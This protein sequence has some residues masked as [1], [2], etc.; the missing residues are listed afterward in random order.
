MS[1]RL[2]EADLIARYFAPLAGPAGLGLRDDAAL[3]RPPPGEDLVLTTDALVAGVHFFAD[4]PPGAIARKA[5][6]VNLSDLAAKGARPLGFLLT[7]ALPCD[8]REDWLAVVRRGSWRGRLGLR[9]PAY[10]RRH[11]VDAWAHDAERDRD[12][13][14]RARADGQ[15]HRRQGRRPPL[16]HGHDRR[17]RDWS[18]GPARAGPRHS[19]GRQGVP[20]RAV[21]DARAAPGADRRDGRARERRHGRLGRLCR[22][23][24]PRCSTSPGSAPRVPI[25][26][27]PL[28]PAARAAIAADPDLFEVA[29]TGGDDYELLAS[30]SPA[31][32]SAFEAAAAA[33]GVP[34]T[35]VGEAVEGRRA[36]AL[37][38]PRW[39]CGRLR[40]RLLQPFLNGD[41]MTE[42]G[43]T[44]MDMRLLAAQ[45]VAREA[46]ALARR[47]FLDHSFTVGFKGPQDYLTEVDGETEA[48]I[49]ERLHRRLS[50]RRLHR[51]REQGARQQARA[52]R[53]GS[54]IRSTAPRTS[55][56]ACRI[57]A[58]RSPAS[59]PARSR[60]ASF[61][62]RCATNCSRPGEAAAR[63]STARRCAPRVRRSLA[64]LRNRGRLEHARGR[65]PICRSPPPGRI[66]RRCA[67]PHRL[68]RARARLCRRRP[69][70]R[71]SSSITSMPGTVLPGFCWSARR[72][73]T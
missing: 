29:A 44:L 5:L 20:A 23:S 45:A 43:S 9:M 69:A 34:L 66:D 68:R 58:S 72:A 73:A 71:L 22:R 60:S 24:R 47:R 55:L 52:G 65:R 32:A 18:E 56:A 35:F 14:G 53:P 42:A 6:R 54:S 21:S 50:D 40:A 3:M 57:S 8:W 7:L 12:R 17:R 41:T 49:A 48:L 4:D 19:A 70:R 11:R 36:A 10:R 15:A 63:G 31:S 46:G 61:T 16:C 26:R 38:R 1:V 51:R 27:L 28:S 25:Y 59:P 62:I 13:L 30:A 39:R 2:G 64:E 37:H 67:L 33:A